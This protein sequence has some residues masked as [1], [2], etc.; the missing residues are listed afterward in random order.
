MLGK[1]YYL[2]LGVSRS[3]SPEGIRHAFRQHVKR[4]HPDRLGHARL[5]FFDKLVEAYRTLSNPER[6]RD[7]DRGL[8]H[9]HEEPGAAAPLALAAEPA[10]GVPQI[11]STLSARYIKDAL[12]DAALA[13]VSRNLIA[14]H[15]PEHGPP[16]RLSVMVILSAAEA[17]RGGTLDI[18]VPSC[19]P[20][21]RCGGTG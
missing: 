2:T 4:Y 13:Q 19:S 5:E 16:R 6:R 1:S 21:A 14:A 18:G 12:F 15:I 7:Y 9:A 11:A 10:S 17:L 20:C 8:S 3:E